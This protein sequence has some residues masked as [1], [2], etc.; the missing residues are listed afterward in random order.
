M[1][2]SISKYKKYLGS[3]ELYKKVSLIA[4]PIALQNLIQIGVNMMDTVML[5]TLGETALSA[6]ALANQFITIYHICSMG[7]GMGASVLVSRFWG[8]KDMKSLKKTVTIMIRLCLGFALI[9]AVLTALFPGQIMRIYTPE[10]DVIR[11]GINYFFWS[12]PTY[13]LLGLSLDCT[14]VIRSMGRA[15]IPLACSILGFMSNLFF[16]YVFI[17]GKFGAPRMEVAGAALGTLI[18]RIIEFA[19][20]GGYFFFIENKLA[21]RIKDIFMKCDDLVKE[22]MII[23]IPVVISDG[24]MALGNSA[25]AMIMGRI[26]TAFVSAN[27]ITTVTQQLTT[28]FTQGVAQAGCI[29]TGHTLGQ[30]D[31]EKAQN[32]GYAFAI[33]GLVMGAIAGFIVFLINGPVVGMY[34]IT[35]E[36]RGIAMQLMSSI[37][38][39]IIFQ[40]TNSILAKGVLRGGGDTRFLM[41]ADVLFLWIASVPLGILA[42]LIWHLPAFWVYFF[43]KID[44]IIKCVWCILRLRSGKWIKAIKGA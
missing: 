36:T 6:S 2:F 8:M 41:V 39:I 32:D 9:F 23:S 15:M 42:G 24:L 21:Y 25:L 13:F 17:F 7:I 11:E 19:M 38:I 33:F 20:I 28:V 34:N 44:Q 16:N 1:S 4:L 18:A 3:V 31:R 27:S 30:G 14:L 12:V 22:Y 35:D 43:I 5:G 40:S 29:V 26:G 37:A 10:Q